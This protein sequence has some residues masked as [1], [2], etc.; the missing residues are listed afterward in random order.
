MLAARM[1]RRALL[2]PTLL[3][4]VVGIVAAC[5][6][7]SGSDCEGDCDRCRACVIRRNGPCT[8]TWST[9]D[10][11]PICADLAACIDE[12]WVDLVGDAV[13]DCQRMC[14]GTSGGAAVELYDESRACV[15]DACTL[16][17]DE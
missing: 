11:D 17:C 8:D 13:V 3:G 4:F 2:L 16:S 5:P 7:G 10:A 12:C 9:C 15:E 1:M 14:R 6:G